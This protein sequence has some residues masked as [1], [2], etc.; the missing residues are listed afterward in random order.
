MLWGVYRFGVLCTY[1]SWGT[2]IPEGTGYW[3]NYIHRGQ[4]N[5][6]SCGPEEHHAYRS[7]MH[8]GWP[9]LHS[10]EHCEVDVPMETR[11]MM[12]RFNVMDTEAI[13][14]VLRTN[15]FAD[16]PQILSLTL[17]APYVLYGD[18]GEGQESVPVEHSEP[19]E[20]T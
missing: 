19:T 11:S 3:G 9:L 2:R 1:L 12:H 20:A 18:H 15:F 7:H 17:P 16:H 14:F 13:D 6:T 5:F 4:E 10:C 8:G